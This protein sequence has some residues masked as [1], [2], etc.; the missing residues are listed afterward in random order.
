MTAALRLALKNRPG[1]TGAHGGGALLIG[2]IEGEAQRAPR[3]LDSPLQLLTVT[4]VSQSQNQETP[5]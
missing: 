5:P 1:Q 4:L 3:L 2:G